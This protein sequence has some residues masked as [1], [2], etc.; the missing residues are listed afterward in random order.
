MEHHPVVTREPTAPTGRGYRWYVGEDG[1]W[2]RVRDSALFPSRSQVLELAVELSR[3]VPGHVMEFGVWKGQSTRAIRDALWRASIWSPRQWTKRI[4]ACDS[5]DG[6]PEGYEHLGAGTFATE[7]PR[8]IGV[9]IVQGF[10]EQSL[11]PALAQEVGRVSLVHLD[12]DLFSATQTVLRWIDPLLSD[13]ALLVFDEF[14]G[15]DPAE[16]R[17]LQEWLESTGRQVLLIGLFSREPSGGGDRTDRRAIFQV[18]GER[19]VPRLPSPLPVRL[20]RRLLSRW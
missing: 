8:L 5:F 12:A 16:E 19:P 1:D 9:R 7:V 13:G 10:F 14:G 18:I 20:R 6:L 11:T 3:S 15:E 17:A 2:S 4:Y